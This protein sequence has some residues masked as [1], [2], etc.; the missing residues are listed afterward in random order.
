MKVPSRLAGLLRGAG[1]CVPDGDE[2]LDGL[3][4]RVIHA[5]ADSIT[6]FG[7]LGEIRGPSSRFEWKHGRRHKRIGQAGRFDLEIV[8]SD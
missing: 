8:N 5:A 7:I 3:G 6:R 1:D 2:P 4:W